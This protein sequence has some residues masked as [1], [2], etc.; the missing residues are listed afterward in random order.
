MSSKRL[1]LLNKDQKRKLV[2]LVFD[3][4]R[5]HGFPYPSLRDYEIWED[6]FALQNMDAKIITSYQPLFEYHTN[7]IEV[8]SEGLRAAECFHHHI[9]G[10]HA[11]GKKSPTDAYQDD[12]LL[13]RS[14]EFLLELNNSVSDVH[15]RRFLGLVKSAQKCSNFRPSAAKAI[16][17]RYLPHDAELVLDPCAGY[18]GRLLGFLSLCLPNV[19][20]IGIDPCGDTCKGNRQMAGFFDRLNNVEML[21]YPFEDVDLSRFGTFDLAFTSPPYF[22]KEIYSDEDTQSCNRYPDYADWIKQF[23]TSTFYKVYS[24]LRYDGLFIINIYDVTIG[25]KRYPLVEDAIKVANLMGFSLKERLEM[26]FPGMGKNVKKKR[27]EPILVFA[28]GDI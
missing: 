8:R 22:K 20:Y 1:S 9:W 19:K 27:A 26:I 13:K 28:K 2:E 24:V 16:Y 3:Y 21:K 25:G 14:V 15:V 7:E 17:K 12:E 10:V 6:F 4:H 5:T 11:I 18:G 23:L